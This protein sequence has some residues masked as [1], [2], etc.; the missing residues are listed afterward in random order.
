MAVSVGDLCSYSVAAD[1]TV[2]I[3]NPSFLWV[4]VLLDSARVDEYATN[5]KLVELI[6]T[7]LGVPSGTATKTYSTKLHIH[8]AK[9]FGYQIEKMTNNLPLDIAYS[10]SASIS[11]YMFP[12]MVGPYS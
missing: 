7:E 2:N 12:F 9:L 10:I 4:D 1:A 11:T 3:Y 8:D 5:T 6:D